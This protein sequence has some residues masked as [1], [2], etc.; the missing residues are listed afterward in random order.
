MEL[1]NRYRTND[2]TG[3]INYRDFVNK[4]DQ[5]FSEVMSPSEVI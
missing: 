4:V 5:V 1:I 2:G 3:L